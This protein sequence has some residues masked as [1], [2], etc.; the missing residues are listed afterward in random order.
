MTT[1]PHRPDVRGLPIK[2]PVT[3][4]LPKVEPL[5]G[6]VNIWYG[7]EGFAVAPNYNTGAAF[8]YDG[9]P[10]GAWSGGTY[11]Q[12]FANFVK[13]IKSRNFRDLGIRFPHPA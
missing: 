11:Q 5:K 4:G 3:F 10:L 12:H 7:T 6:A 13:A 9:N 1:A 8:D 2:S